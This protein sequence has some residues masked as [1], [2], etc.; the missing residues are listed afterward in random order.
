MSDPTVALVTG[1]SRGIGRAVVLELAR[2][3]YSVGIGFRDQEARAAE[4]AREVEALGQKALLLKA[5]VTDAAQVARLFEDAERQLGPVDVLVCGAGVTRDTLL[6]ASTPED[7]D[8]V[9]A[10]NL[11]GVVHCCREATKR[12]LGRRRGSIVALSSVAGQRPGRGQSLYAATKGAVESFVRA[13]AVE[14]AP[15]NIRVNAVAPG[16]IETEMTRDILA[17]APDEVKK[18]ILLRRPGR[19]EEVAKVVAFLCSSDASYVTGQVWNV[20]GGFK[21]E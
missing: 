3:G 14:L 4:V 10:I 13:L 18:R 15:R 2:R 6:G 20:D 21:L 5:D 19:P 7:L 1:G 9:R 16:V 8:A 11:D 17:L 12:M